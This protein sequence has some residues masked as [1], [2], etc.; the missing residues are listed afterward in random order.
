MQ[1]DAKTTQN[2]LSNQA[3]TPN[4]STSTNTPA[5]ETALKVIELSHGFTIKAGNEED[6]TEYKTY[7]HIELYK[8]GQKIFTDD[9]KLEY[10]FNHTQYP[11][12]LETAE[13]TYELLFEINDRPLINYLKRL[14]VKNNV[15]YKQDILPTFMGDAKDVDHDNIEEYVGFRED[16]EIWNNSEGEYVT[17]YVPILFYS[18]TK[19]GIEPDTTLTLFW[20][21]KIYGDF[22][23]YTPN[24]KVVVPE[25]TY[26]HVLKVADSLIK[27]D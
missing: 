8:D 16:A 26:N 2:L 18:K 20:N 6:L 25:S 15:V 10:Q 17:Y 11:I 14:F 19:N 1:N 13:N 3:E 7:S 12:V 9:N 5:M 4:E 24:T 27:A 21:K 22:Y 23:G